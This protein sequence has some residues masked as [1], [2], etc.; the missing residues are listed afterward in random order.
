MLVS[1]IIETNSLSHS[2]AEL[3]ISEGEPGGSILSPDPVVVPALIRIAGL[4]STIDSTGYD[5]NKDYLPLHLRASQNKRN[6]AV[7]SS[8]ETD[9]IKVPLKYL[10]KKISH[11]MIL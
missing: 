3:F 4:P 10:N 11:R 1:E 8:A 6:L 2:K 5:M 9:Y 7:D